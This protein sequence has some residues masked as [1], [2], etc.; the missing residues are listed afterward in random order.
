MG[1]VAD[2]MMEEAQR[3]R[4]EGAWC[5][6]HRQAYMP[7]LP[8]QAC[9]D[10]EPGVEEMRRRRQ[11]RFERQYGGE[12][13]VAWLTRQPCMLANSGMCEGR[14]DP[15]HAKTKGAGGEWDAIVPLCRRHHETVHRAGV[16]TVRL[17]T[18]VDLL[19]EARSLASRWVESHQELMRRSAGF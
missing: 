5:E 11:E 4:D 8:C 16:Q 13:Y 1:D 14:I 10:G 15:H 19:R 18:G 9:E 3:W 7:P 17:L 2:A 12:E 6:K